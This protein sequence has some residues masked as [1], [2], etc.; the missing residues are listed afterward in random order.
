VQL[1]NTVDIKPLHPEDLTGDQF[2]QA[3]ARAG[4]CAAALEGRH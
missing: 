4:G 3:S 1:V 2:A